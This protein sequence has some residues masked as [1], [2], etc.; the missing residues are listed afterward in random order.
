MEKAGKRTLEAIVTGATAAVIGFANA[1][2]VA[3]APVDEFLLLGLPQAYWIVTR[4]EQGMSAGLEEADSDGKAVLYAA[5][6][7]VGGG[8]GG[9]IKSGI[10]Q[11]FGYF[12]GYGF[13]SLS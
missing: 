12:V 1:K 10:C 3:A 6:G 13:G 11:L 7:L 8:I 9:A 5:A 2:G 4:A